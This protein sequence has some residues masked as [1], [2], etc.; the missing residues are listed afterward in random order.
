MVEKQEEVERKENLVTVPN[1]LGAVRLLASPWLIF[2]GVAG[3]ETAFLVLF[4]VLTFTDWIDGK[5][6]GWLD[7]R[8]RIG[9]RLDTLADVTMYAALI[10]GLG[11]LE[12]RLFVDEW[13]WLVAGGASYLVSA[14]VSQWKFGRFPSYHTRAAKTSWFLGLVAAVALVVAGWVWPLRLAAVAV[15]VTNLEATLITRVL[16]APREN[17]SSVFALLGDRDR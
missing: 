6:A 15:T 12:G 1:V 7:Q 9:P 2:L 10:L 5:L 17:L 14:V 8:S 13:P 4:L 16:G 3:R 11:W